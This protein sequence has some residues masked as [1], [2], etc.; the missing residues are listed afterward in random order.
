MKMPRKGE[1]PWQPPRKGEPDTGCRMSVF[2]A[3]I[4]DTKAAVEKIKASSPL[5]RDLL[6]LLDGI[7]ALEPLSGIRPGVNQ[8]VTRTRVPVSVPRATLN[9]EGQIDPGKYLAFWTCPPKGRIGI[10]AKVDVIPGN[11]IATDHGGV[12]YRKLAQNSLKDL[13]KDWNFP[14]CGGFVTTVENI[15]VMPGSGL[16]VYL[17]NYSRFGEALFSVE[18]ET[19]S[20]R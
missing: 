11:T 20:A 9:D 10:A 17:M 5:T 6:C 2:D 19:W 13:C 1:I 7:G 15:V 18:V 16:S 8:A 4:G 3:A 12:F 14:D